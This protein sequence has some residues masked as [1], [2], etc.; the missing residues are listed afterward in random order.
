MS[1]TPLHTHHGTRWGPRTRLGT[2]ALSLTGLALAGTVALTIA[3]AAGLQSADSFTDNW[4]LTAV[5]AAILVSAAASAV[6]GVI[7]T[8][9]HHDHSWSVVSATGT[10]V[11]LTALFLQQLSEGLGW[12]TG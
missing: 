8:I 10:G 9:S 5:G 11:L 6:T 7:A 1:T 4:I 3:F 2:W 12:L